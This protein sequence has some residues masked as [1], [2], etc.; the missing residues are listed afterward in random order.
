[1]RKRYTWTILLA[2]VLL[3][4]CTENSKSP[5]VS[6]SPSKKPSSGAP[7]VAFH[8]DLT[9]TAATLLSP[10]PP[11]SENEVLTD[12][13]DTF[14]ARF[15]RISC[16]GPYI[17]INGY[18]A[19]ATELRHVQ[20]W[21]SAH[22]ALDYVT[23]TADSEKQCRDEKG[24]IFFP[25]LKK[26]LLVFPVGY[27]SPG[28]FEGQIVY[29][30]GSTETEKCTVT[31]PSYNQYHSPFTPPENKKVKM[32]EA[33]TKDGSGVPHTFQEAE[34]FCAQQGQRL[35]TARELALMQ[36]NSSFDQQ[37]VG[38]LSTPES[39]WDVTSETPSGLEH[40]SLCPNIKIEIP[41][42]DLMAVI[43]PDEKWDYFYFSYPW[44]PKLKEYY[45]TTSVAVQR[46]GA[47]NTVTRHR[48]IFNPSTKRFNYEITPIETSGRWI[49]Q[50]VAN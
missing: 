30:D 50:C 13:Q 29:E 8:Q 39:H 2:G 23:L 49:V 28:D 14:G 5:E 36:I 35:P 24:R 10:M 27:Q 22:G 40:N 11:A 46:D 42:F 47:N 7:S 9:K 4:A 43:N 21:T 33:D 37:L 45:W 12:V 18:I 44:L 38:E 6:A 41:Q 15:K 25:L 3:G 32:G 17:H 26:T 19:S 20:P 48:V 31:E 1:M 34:K 16:T